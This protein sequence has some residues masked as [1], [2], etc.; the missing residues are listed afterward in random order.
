MAVIVIS[1]DQS[2]LLDSNEDSK[3]YFLGKFLI[4][5]FVLLLVA[6]VVDS[7]SNKTTVIETVESFVSTS[8]DEALINSQNELSLTTQ[9]QVTTASTISVTKKPLELPVTS[10]VK[11]T[12]TVPTPTPTEPPVIEDNVEIDLVLVSTTDSSVAVDVTFLNCEAQN[13]EISIELVFATHT[14]DIG[15]GNCSETV[16]GYK[17]DLGTNLTFNLRILHGSVLLHERDVLVIELD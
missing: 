16:T 11:E 9:N 4:S 2:Q 14:Y 8:T 6:L 3:F 5:L 1:V 15:T 7:F 17:D 12:T 13:T 10:Q